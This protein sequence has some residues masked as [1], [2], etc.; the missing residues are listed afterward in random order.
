M[1]TV[2]TTSNLPSVRVYCEIAGLTTT[3]TLFE[4]RRGSPNR[5]VCDRRTRRG[6]CSN[7]AWAVTAIEQDGTIIVTPLSPNLQVPPQAA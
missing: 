5:G 4:K 3:A 6:F 1:V 2:E 7:C